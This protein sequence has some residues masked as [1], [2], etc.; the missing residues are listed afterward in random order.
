MTDSKTKSKTNTKTKTKKQLEKQYKVLLH[1]DDST[2]MEFVV[3]A[4]MSIFEQPEPVA[5]AIML[6]V[7]QSGVGIAGVYDKGVANDK[8]VQTMKAARH[9]GY[10]LVCSIEEL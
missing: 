10:P 8:A 4:L 3:C 7:H 5:E 2:T 9:E 1:N 6:A